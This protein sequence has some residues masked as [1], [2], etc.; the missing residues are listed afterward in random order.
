MEEILN[1]FTTLSVIE[2]E[3]ES[4]SYN[5][6]NVITEFITYIEN[7]LQYDIILK[8][9]TGHFGNM[10]L[11]DKR[12]ILS[13][14]TDVIELLGVRNS[15]GREKYTVEFSKGCFTC[16]CKDYTFR[17]KKLNIVCKHISFLVCKV[18][19]ILDYKFFDTLK[20]SDENIIIF[21]NALNSNIIWDNRYL[22]VKNI[23][24]KFNIN[25]KEFNIEDTCPI[26]YEYFLHQY[27]CISCPECNNYVHKDCMNIWLEENN[28][29]V[30]CRDSIWG[31][32]IDDITLI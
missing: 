14:D 10:Y 26:C 12:N 1:N 4:M 19:R 2:K 23:N 29:C 7:V 24:S 21:K 11:V 5:Y 32:Y 25:K 15:K 27:N 6:N 31:N 9:F 3:L 30:Y 22:S 16:N 28:S 13:T 20:L 17:C 18:S 8:L